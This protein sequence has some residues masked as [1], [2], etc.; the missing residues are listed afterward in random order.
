MR[1]VYFG[2]TGWVRDC[3]V[4]QRE[5]LPPGT[6]LPGPMIVEQMDTTTVV[7]PDFDLEVDAATNLILRLRPLERRDDATR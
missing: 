2:G 6:R 3:P 7:P 5:T 4:A 1:P